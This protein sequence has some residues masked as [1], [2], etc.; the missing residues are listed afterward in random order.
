MALSQA[1]VSAIVSSSRST[2][3]SPSW[4]PSVV[5][6]RLA[7]GMKS[8]DAG[9]LSSARLRLAKLAS[10]AFLGVFAVDG[11]VDLARGRGFQLFAA[12][13]GSG[14]SILD[15]FADRVLGVGHR[16]T[17]ALRSLLGSLHGF[18]RAELDGLAPNAV[19]LA[20]PRA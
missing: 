1:W 19:H 16:N 5:A 10:R 7:T 20:A 11:R 13:L 14:H 3:R 8:D 15:C 9:I 2:R 18:A 6:T 17:R 4:L 12:P